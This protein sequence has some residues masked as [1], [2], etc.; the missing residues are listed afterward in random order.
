MPQEIATQQSVEILTALKKLGEELSEQEEA[1]LQTNS[2]TNL[3]EF[4]K[5]S[6]SI[7]KRSVMLG[8]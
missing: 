6:G 7:G 5:V 1:Y 2:S 3:K 8:R 4:E